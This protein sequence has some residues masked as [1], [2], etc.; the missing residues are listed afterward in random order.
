MKKAICHYSFHRRWA[1]EKWTAERLAEE[2]KALGIECVDFHAGMMAPAATAAERIQAA[3]S[4]TGLTLSEPF[5]GERFQQGK[6]E[7]IQGAGGRR[8][9][10]DPRGG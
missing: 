5:A 8:Q 10:V 6:P 7:G 1:A 9:R 3:L 4:K 2:V